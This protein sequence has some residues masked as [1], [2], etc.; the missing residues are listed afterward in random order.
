MTITT[1]SRPIVST[2]MWRLRPLIFLPASYPRVCAETVSAA[3]TDCE[4][5]IPAEG[6]GSRRSSLTRTRSRSASC[7]RSSVPSS[8]QARKYQYTVCHGGKSLGRI[9]HEH[10]VRVRYTIALTTSRFSWLAGRARYS[11]RSATRLDQY[12]LAGGY[13]A[14]RGRGRGCPLPEALQA[15]GFHAH[16][17][18][19][20]IRSATVK[21]VRVRASTRYSPLASARSRSDSP[22]SRRIACA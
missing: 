9:R 18:S 16:A 15:D 12:A 19:P 6:S 14:A 2:T 21:L 8:H 13:R 3:L 20:S 1:S 4:S 7:S 17:D 22:S 5:T 11:R 10:P